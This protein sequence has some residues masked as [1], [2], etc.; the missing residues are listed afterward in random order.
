MIRNIGTIEQTADDGR[1]LIKSTN[2]IWERGDV[3]RGDREFWNKHKAL[4]VWLTGLSGSGKSTIARILEKELF[5]DNIRAFRLDGDNVRHGLC[6]DLGFSAEDRRKNIRRVGQAAK[7]L[8]D[9]GQV[10][11]CSFISPYAEDRKFVRDLFPKDSFV[12]VYVKCS[13]EECIR[14]DPK[15]LYKKALSDEI[16]NFTGISDPYEEPENADF[17]IDTERQSEIM[18]VENIYPELIDRIKLS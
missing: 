11:L 9:S 7:L 16:Q 14:R 17:V 15:G 2:I 3:D 5:S 6:S 4:C 8:F 10:V 1:D 12:E 13:I 18:S